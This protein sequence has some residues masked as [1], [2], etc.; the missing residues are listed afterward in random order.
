M[1]P[2]VILT[3][4]YMDFDCNEYITVKNALE[5]NGINV[6][7]ASTQS[8]HAVAHHPDTT[9]IKEQNPETVRV[10][11]RVNEIDPLSY[12]GMFVI[13]GQGAREYL[14]VY[15]VHAKLK[16]FCNFDLYYGAIGTACRVLAEAGVLDGCSATGWNDDNQLSGIFARN[17]CTYQNEHLVVSGKAITATSH[18][19]QRFG[20]TIA[21]HVSWYT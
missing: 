13:G 4:A 5:D 14:D 7:I 19:A 21:E 3:L 1:K 8:G 11:L 20:E 17:G 15:E 2:C 10:D 18:A 16:E 6:T 12:Q 9:V